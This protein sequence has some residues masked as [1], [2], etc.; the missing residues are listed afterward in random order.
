MGLD[1]SSGIP[2]TEKSNTAITHAACLRI[3]LF[4]Q[5]SHLCLA[6]EVQLRHHNPPRPRAPCPNRKSFSISLTWKE[7][8]AGV[9]TG[10]NGVVTEAKGWALVINLLGSS[11]HLSACWNIYRM[12]VV[13]EGSTWRCLLHSCFYPSSFSSLYFIYV[14]T[15]GHGDSTSPHHSPSDVNSDI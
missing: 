6:T 4:A 15:E 7:T 9:P 14:F 11:P 1:L 8:Q 3:G 10:Q 2:G 5:A 13:Q 12:H